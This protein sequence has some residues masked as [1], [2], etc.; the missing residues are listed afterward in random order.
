MIGIDNFL[1]Q[2]PDSEIGLDLNLEFG[3]WN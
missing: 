1:F 3:I 2:I